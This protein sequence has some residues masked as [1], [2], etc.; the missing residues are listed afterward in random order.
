MKNSSFDQL[1]IPKEY[2]TEIL[3][4]QKEPTKKFFL[5]NNGIRNIF[6]MPENSVSNVKSVS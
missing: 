4:Q 1:R 6:S 5:S 2:L 3:E